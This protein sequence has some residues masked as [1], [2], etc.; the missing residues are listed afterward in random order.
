MEDITSFRT[1]AE[2]LY[3]VISIVYLCVWGLFLYVALTS[4]SPG[5]GGDF[6]IFLVP[7]SLPWFLGSAWAPIFIWRSIVDRQRFGITAT[8]AKIIIYSLSFLPLLYVFI[9]WLIG[10][11]RI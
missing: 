9:P 8:V 7:L 10:Y 3:F 1:G 4:G 2:K 11:L 5:G 6:V